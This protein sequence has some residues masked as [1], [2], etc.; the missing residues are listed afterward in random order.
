MFYSA[1]FFRRQVLLRLKTDRMGAVKNRSLLSV[2]ARP[3]L[4]GLAMAAAPK[5][6]PLRTGERDP[7][8]A[9]WLDAASCVHSETREWTFRTNISLRRVK[10]AQIRRVGS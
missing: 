3:A 1:V 9:A 5:P 4:H 8:A 10:V 6:T 7:A 2:Q